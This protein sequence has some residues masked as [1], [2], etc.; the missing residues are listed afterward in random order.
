MFISFLAPFYVPFYHSK[1]TKDVQ[2]LLIIIIFIQ[3]K[4]PLNEN[5]PPADVT[6]FLKEL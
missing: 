4:L 5:K 2:R 1:V 3:R 6:D